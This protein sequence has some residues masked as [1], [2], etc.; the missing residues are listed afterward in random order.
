MELDLEDGFQ[1]HTYR[2]LHN[3]VPQAWDSKLAHFA[4]S[5]GDFHTPERLRTVRTAL[6]FQAQRFEPGPE[7]LFELPNPDAVHACRF[8]T[9]AY[10]HAI[11]SRRDPRWIVHQVHQAADPAFVWIG[12]EQRRPRLPGSLVVPRLL[13]EPSLDVID[14][15]LEASKLKNT[16]SIQPRIILHPFAM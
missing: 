5:L 14:V 8:A 15:H 6:Q 4:V 10:K 2:L 9:G 16:S 7:S 13:P 12:R 1:R 3:F 11:T